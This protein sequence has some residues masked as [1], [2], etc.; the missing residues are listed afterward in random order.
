MKRVDGEGG[1]A[2]S[3]RSRYFDCLSLFVYRP[4]PLIFELGIEQL[5]FVSSVLLFYWVRIYSFIF[6]L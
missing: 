2:G 1:W 4:I 5:C 3:R 6:F